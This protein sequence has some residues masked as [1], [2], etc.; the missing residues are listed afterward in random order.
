MKNVKDSPLKADLE[1]L[2]FEE[3]ELSRKKLAK[4]YDVRRTA[5]D[6]MWQEIHH[7]DNGQE[8]DEE[9]QGT[10]VVFRNPDP[11][12]LP[13]KGGEL[14]EDIADIL[15]KYLILPA[16]AEDAIALWI[17][18]AHAHDCATISPILCIC[19]PQKRCGKST[20]IGILTSL[21]LRPLPS[22]NV[23][24]AALF[25]ATEKWKP[26]LLID[27]ADTFIKDNADL[28]G[29]LNSGHCRDQAFVLR[30][31]GDD[32]EPRQFST[33]APK[34]I[35]LIGRMPATLMDRAIVINMRRKLPSE[36]VERFRL[37]RRESFIFLQS[38]IARFVADNTDAIADADPAIPAKNDRQ[39]DNWRPLYAIA[40][41]AGGDWIEKAK[42]AMLALSTDE[43]EDIKIEL[44]KDIKLVFEVE[45]H[46]R[47][48]STQL[49]EKLAELEERPWGQ[50]GRS[51]KAITPNQIARML[52]DF[53]I[54]SK[55]IKF[56][57]S[58]LKG[59][60]KDVFTDAWQRYA[61]PL[62][63][64]AN[65]LP[66]KEIDSNNG[67]ADRVTVASRNATRY[68]SAT[69]EYYDK[70]LWDD[71]IFGEPN[72]SSGVAVESEGGENMPE[73]NDN[74]PENVKI[75]DH[76]KG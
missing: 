65:G 60:K 74:I 64:H 51:V 11:W 69:D 62:P 5:L 67:V 23:T 55:N 37:D 22:A 32:Y 36:E 50:W 20:L 73:F 16:G 35:A 2:S 15:S 1:S 46:D 54:K 18:H 48:S 53:S 43:E 21:V 44:L 30:T 52:R 4:R 75:W 58:V 24:P 19:S 49:A 31:S 14:L 61:T 27:E 13:V 42:A 45:L 33:W 71:E 25:R 56:G 28:R 6:Q 72:E 29:I 76:I 12:K 38:K 10:A 39:A 3:Y 68:Q 57:E 8:H 26:T 7:G 34:A 41:I 59:Y 70:S 9:R 66:G 17:I 63:E 40:V 47:I